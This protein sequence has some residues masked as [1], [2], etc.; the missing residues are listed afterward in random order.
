[1]TVNF[2]RQNYTSDGTP[3]DIPAGDRPFATQKVALLPDRFVFG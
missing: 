1:M 2:G 3:K